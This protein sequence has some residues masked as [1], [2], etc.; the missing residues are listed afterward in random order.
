MEWE[1]PRF[2]YCGL[3]YAQIS[4]RHNFLSLILAVVP[5]VACSKYFSPGCDLGQFYWSQY[6]LEVQLG[7]LDLLAGVW[8]LRPNCFSS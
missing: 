4:L 2:K 7:R 6:E 1:K 8:A 5:P 3:L